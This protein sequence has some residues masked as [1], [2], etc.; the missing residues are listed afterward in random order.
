MN[1]KTAKLPG[2]LLLAYLIFFCVL[3]VSP[4]DRSVWFVENMT[5]LPIVLVLVFTYRKFQ[6]SNLSY[7]M[8]SFLIFM[9]TFGGHY[10]FALVPFG[11]I[12][13]LF[14]FERNHYDRIAHFTV[15]F[16]AFP[17]GEFIQ[18]RKLSN[19]LVLTCLFSVFTIC[20]VALL[21]ELFEWIYA[22]TAN[23]NAGIAILG[24]QGDIWDAQK[25]MLSDTLG[26]VVAAILFYAV[27]RGKR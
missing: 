4:Y 10:S 1:E 12:T 22:V 7:I 21:Y 9:H 11:F 5:I 17:I 3:A 24:S 2:M 18:R 14:G 19:S 13:D 15:G 8:M 20:T 26:A 27:Y 6:F 25:D 16:Y 23:P